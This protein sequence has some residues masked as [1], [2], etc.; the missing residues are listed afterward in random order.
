MQLDADEDGEPFYK[1]PVV[2]LPPFDAKPPP[3]AFGDTL[4]AA[5]TGAATAAT[6]A[7][8]NYTGAS[9]ERESESAQHGESEET[10]VGG[11]VDGGADERESASVSAVGRGE[12]GG[13]RLSESTTIRADDD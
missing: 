7:N 5:G 13:D 12:S 10:Q 1:P 6:G 8:H 4:A 9:G 11:D 2:P 3:G